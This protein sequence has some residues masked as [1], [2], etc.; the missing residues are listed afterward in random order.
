MSSILSGFFEIQK[1]LVIY[2][3]KQLH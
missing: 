1:K 2:I 3:T